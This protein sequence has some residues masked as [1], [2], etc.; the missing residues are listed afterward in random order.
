MEQNQAVMVAVDAAGA[1]VGSY[2][3]RHNSLALAAHV[4]NAGSEARRL[5]PGVPAEVD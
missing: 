3:L 2:Y 4:A 1:V 5:E